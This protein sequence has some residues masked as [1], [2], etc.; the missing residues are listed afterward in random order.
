VTIGTRQKERLLCAADPAGGRHVRYPL[1][2]CHPKSQV[3]HALT[4]ALLWWEIEDIKSFFLNFY[5]FQV[6]GG[7]LK[8]TQNKEMKEIKRKRKL[9][10]FGPRLLAFFLVGIEYGIQKCTR[11]P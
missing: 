6:G 5:N 10:V 8:W 2:T 9:Y 11:I 7:I 1:L 3:S 4:K